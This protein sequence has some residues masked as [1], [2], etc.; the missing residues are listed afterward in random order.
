MTTAPVLITPVPRAEPEAFATP[1]PARHLRLVGHAP[2]LTIDDI[3]HAPQLTTE[4]VG[5][6]GDARGHRTRG[7]SLPPSPAG[8][9][10]QPDQFTRTFFVALAEVLVGRRSAHQLAGHLALPIQQWL[11]SV[12]AGRGAGTGHAAAPR[13]RTVH[14]CGVTPGVL[15]A[16]AVIQHGPHV[17][18][19]NGRFVDLDGRWQCV[20]LELV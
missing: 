3:D 18:A 2:Q 20:H 8:A 9:P 11:R 15:E 16:T 12:L 6:S 19:M 1:Q 13:V 17:R 10:A 14:L 5:H 7:R 4:D